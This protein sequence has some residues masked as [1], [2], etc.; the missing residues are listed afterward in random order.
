MWR[1]QVPKKL[2]L[3]QVGTETGIEI[4]TEIEIE[5]GWWGGLCLIALSLQG[6]VLFVRG[7]GLELR[8][9]WSVSRGRTSPR[10]QPCH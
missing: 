9:V 3:S 8:A 10:C 2:V 6:P 4:E 1:S 7:P 5:R